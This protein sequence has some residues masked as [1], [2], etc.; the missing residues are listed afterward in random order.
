ML[1]NTVRPAS[2]YARTVGCL[3]V[4][5]GLPN[6]HLRIRVCLL[7]AASDSLRRH[8]KL[9]LEPPSED[10]VDRVARACDLCHVLKCKCDRNNPCTACARRGRQCTFDRFPNENVAVTRSSSVKS[11][12]GTDTK[13][14][15]MIKFFSFFFFFLGCV[16]SDCNRGEGNAGALTLV[17][18]TWMWTLQLSTKYHSHHPQHHQQ[19]KQEKYQ[20]TI[21][22]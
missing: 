20:S 3:L 2:L 13:V 17:R 6:N 19:Q 14:H 18:I 16:C 4:G 21:F 11:E 8:T 15:D 5:R 22:E 1:S 12:S 10:P 9:H 7:T